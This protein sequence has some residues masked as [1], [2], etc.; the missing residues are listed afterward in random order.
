MIEML[1]TS[2]VSEVQTWR[3]GTSAGA[4]RTPE[5]LA[6]RYRSFPSWSDLQGPL[7]PWS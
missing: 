1:T 5:C 4:G 6:L 2:F 7:G 3:W